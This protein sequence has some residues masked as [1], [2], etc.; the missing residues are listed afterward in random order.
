MKRIECLP[1]AKRIVVKV[2]TAVISTPSGR[3]DLER[4][5]NLVIQMANLAKKGYQLLLVTSGAIAAGLERL[6]KEERPSA[7]PEL[8]AAASVGQG[9]LLQQYNN[10]FS[11][12]DLKVGQVLL[13]QFDIIHRE[14]YVNASNTFEKLF[15]LGVIPVVNENDTT[16]V[17]EIKFG[18]NDTLAALVA[19]L[20]K[21]DALIVLTDTEGLYTTDPRADTKAKLIAEVQ[22]ITSEIERL[23]GGKGTEFGSGGMVTKVRAARIVTLA[24]ASMVVADGRKPN[25]LLDIMEGKEVGTFFAPHKKKMTSRK[26]WIAFGRTTKGTIIVDDGAKEALRGKGRSLLAAGV[27]SCEGSFSMGDAVDIADTQGNVFAKGLINFNA[28]ELNQ[29]K[30]LK[31]SEV[32]RVLTGEASEE[33]IHRDCLVILK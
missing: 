1:K 8:Q 22:E 23:A 30:G 19:N 9:L 15:E 12:H 25:V 14:Q 29:I 10:L 5:N 18:D 28:Q 26:A 3:L 11:Q 6:G 17:E 27:L 31:S 21:A 24:G 32:S 33:V 2:G 16:A 7:I 4:M 13:T 20:V